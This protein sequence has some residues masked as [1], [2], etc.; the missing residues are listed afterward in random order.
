VHVE[1]G[2][3]R[4]GAILIE[5]AARER[6]DD[7]ALAPGAPANAAAGFKAVDLR[8]PDVQQDDLRQ[9]L[10]C[11]PHGFDAVVRD[12][13]RSAVHVEE[14]LQHF[15]GVAVIVDDQ[16]PDRSGCALVA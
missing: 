10:F 9:Q 7:H 16:Y 13:C 5:A 11:E 14:D 6:D 1:S 12:I 8:K 15:D 4:H 3:L 2:P